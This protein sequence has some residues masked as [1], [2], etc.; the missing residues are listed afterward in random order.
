MLYVS[1]QPLKGLYSAKNNTTEIYLKM[2]TMVTSF[3]IR[4]YLPFW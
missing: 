2:M 4:L 1:V 3:L